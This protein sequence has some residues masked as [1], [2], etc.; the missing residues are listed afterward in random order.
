VSRFIYIAR[1]VPIG[2]PVNIPE[3]NGTPC[4][5]TF[6]PNTFETA[7]KSRQQIPICV[8]HDRNC[9]VGAVQMLYAR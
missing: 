4:Y 5:T 8:G 3:E 1:L 6:E 7:R 9:T 2:K